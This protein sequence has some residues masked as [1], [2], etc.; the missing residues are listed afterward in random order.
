MASVSTQVLQNINGMR[1]E[2]IDFGARVKSI[3]LPINGQL[4]EMTLTYDEA[5]DF[6]TDPYY[7]GATC[8]P[9]CN[10]IKD[11][12]MVVEGTSYSLNKNDG[13][14]CLHSGED[15][16]SLRFWR[17]AEVTDNS[18]CYQL[19][20]ADQEIGFPGNVEYS[21]EYKLTDSNRLEI[22][23]HAVSDKTSA[24]NLTNHCYFTL[25]EE[26]CADLKVLLN[27]DSFLEKYSDGLP[28]GEIIDCNKLGQSA[29]LKSD[30]KISRLIEQSNYQQVIDES[31]FDHCFV[32]Q[33]SSFK[34]EKARLTSIK[35]GIAV[36]VYTDQPC[37]QFYTG[38]FLSGAFDAYQGVCLESQGYVDAVN[39]LQFPSILV[40][41]N[42]RYN[43]RVSYQFDILEG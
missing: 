31:G 24:I 26:S 37:I 17:A 29:N 7:I 18:V 16:L 1:V 23:Y 42:T 13:E 9:V 34:Q 32:L 28:T 39:Q 12:K 3:K 20:I 6:L 35:N 10:R 22:N 40:D 14:N 25:G 19:M 8:G 5:N 15:N 4:T 43:K 11:A 36:S 38:K 21:V 27:A 2:L 41:K 33:K 30:L